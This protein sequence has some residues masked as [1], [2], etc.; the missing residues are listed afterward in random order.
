MVDKL[1]QKIGS[2]AEIVGKAIVDEGLVVKENGNVV[3]DSDHDIADSGLKAVKIDKPTLVTDTLLVGN[4]DEDMEHGMQFAVTPE[5]TLV[6]G[7]IRQPATDRNPTATFQNTTVANLTVN[8]LSEGLIVSNNFGELSVDS[9]VDLTELHALEGIS[10]NIQEQINDEVSN[11][12]SADNEL[13][14]KLDTEK[15][16]RE[17]EDDSLSGRI[18][19]EVS[20]RTSEVASLTEAIQTE[21]DARLEED[22][23]LNAK[24]DAEISDREEDVSELNNAVAGLT[25]NLN[26]ETTARTRKDSELQTA[27][28]TEVSTRTSEVSGLRTD[29]TTETTERTQ[30]ISGL[31]DSLNSEIAD[32]Q[33]ADGLLRTA[34]DNEV[35][36]RTN[37]DSALD[38][39]L[40][41]IEERIVLP[42]EGQ[43]TL[44]KTSDLN[45][46]IGQ[47]NIDLAK[48]V[49]K[50]TDTHS[51]T[52]V[53]YV[54][55]SGGD[56]TY[57]PISASATPDAIA[58]RNPNGTV[59]VPD[60]NMGGEA[61]NKSYVDSEVQYT[62][63][64]LQE[65]VDNRD[66]PH[67][68]SKEQLG[69]Q[70]VEN[71]P[72]D[73]D[74]MP[75]SPNYVSS[76][77]VSAVIDSVL[78]TIHAHTEDLDNPHRVSK[79]QLDL[80]NVVNRSMD[81]QPES[82]SMNYVESGGV[83]TA[84]QD[85]VGS[86]NAHE[87]DE[88]NPHNVTKEQVG[89]GNVDNTSDMNKP[90]STAQREEFNAI[91]SDLDEHIADKNNPH[92]VTKTQVGLQYVENY[93]MDAV[94]TSSSSN[95]VS[96]GGVYDEIER[97]VGLIDGH[98]SDDRNPHNVTKEQVGL[99]NVDNTS[100]MAKPVSTAQQTAIDGVQSNLDDHEDDTN[101]P[102]N[103]TKTQVGLGNVDNTSDMAK[104]VSTAQSVAIGN[105]QSALDTHEQT[106]ATASTYGHVKMDGT[107]GDGNRTDVT[108]SEAG[109]KAYVNS[110][111]GT[112]TA[113]FLGT[114]NAVADLGFTQTVVDTW[115]DPPASAVEST[116]GNAITSVLNA[117][118]ITPTS[119]DYVFVSVNE[120][121]TTDIDWYWRFK[122]DGSVWLYEYTL[123][124]SSFTQ[125][126]WDA[127]NS[128]IS[129][130][131]VSNYNNH[132]ASR[133]NPHG[134]TKAQVGLG[135]VDNTSDLSKPIS[136]ATQTALDN[137]VGTVN[138]TGS[139]Y[140]SAV[141]IDTND[142]TKLN[143]TRTAIPNVAVTG[144]TAESGKY[145]S[146]I[147]TNGHGI[148]VTK[149][150]LPSLSKGTTTGSGNVVS[151]IS[152]SE[153]TITLTKGITAIT[154][155]SGKA[156][157]NLNNISGLDTDNA[158]KAILVSSTG[159]IEFGEAG[160]VDDVQLNGTSV[161]SNK[162]ANLPAYP[163]VNNGTFNIQGNGTT[164]SSFGANQS[165]TTTL[166]IK[167][168]G[169]TTVT[170][171]ANNEITIS[172]GTI[173]TVNNGTLN[174]KGA[175]T[176]V[177]SFTAN[178]SATSNLD[179]V[180]DGSTT[181]TPDAT[182][183]KITISTPVLSTVATSGS[184]NDLSNKPTI[185]TVYNKT[186]KING[187]STTVA[188]FTS[189]SNTDV[190]VSVVG[191]GSTTVTPDATN[192]KITISTP[193]LSTVATSGS[194]NDLSN[195][196]TIPTVNNG[197]LNIQGNGTTAGSFTAN[198]SGT[199]NI[200]LV[201]GGGTTVT[202]DATNKKITISTTLPTVNNG[203]LTI[204]QNGTS[205]GTFSANQSS[206]G[207]I[208]LTDTWT[209]MT[210]ATSSADGTVGY[211]NA[212]PPKNGYNTKY[213]RADGTWTVPPDH[214]Y[215]VNNGTL[216]IKGENT[217]ATTFTA[218]SST[219]PTLAIKGSGA[220]TVTGASGT[221]TVSST[222]QSVTAVGNHYVPSG[223][224]TTSASG[225]ADTNITNLASGSGVN[226][227]TG[228]TLDDAGHVT[229]ITSKALRSVNNT[230]TVN[231]GKLSLQ[232]NGTEVASFTANQ[233]SGSTFNLANG[234]GISLT[235]DTTNKKI[236]VNGVAVSKTSA[237]L[238]PALPDETTTTKFLRQDGSWQVPAYPTVN[239]GT[240]SIQGNGTTASTFTANQSGNTTLNI[241]GS[242]GTSV[243][244]SANNEIT[245]SSTAVGNGTLT[246]KQN[247]TSK[248]TF[249]ANATGNTTVEL[250]DTTYSAGDGLTLSGTEIS[251]TYPI[252]YARPNETTST[253][254]L[255][256]TISNFPSAY[257]D[258]IM[259]ALRMPFNNVASSTLNVNGLG[260]KNVYYGN[261]T[262]TATRWGPAGCISLLVYETTTTTNGCWKAVYSW[263]SGNTDTKARQTLQTGNYNLPLL[264]SYVQTS[265][266]T[267]NRD[268]VTYRNNSIYANPSTGV[269]TA[270]GFA[271][272]LTGNVTGN[273][274]GSAGSVAWGNV[275]GRP[276]KLSDL[277]NDVVNN[278]TLTIQKNGTDVQTFTANQSTNATAN[279]TV[280]TKT[281]D[282]T[283]DSGFVTS[284]G[285]TSVATGVG[286]TGGTITG[287]GTIKA[288]LKSETASTL[289][290]A[291]ITSTASRQ[292]AVQVDK[293]GYLSVN[294]PWTNVNSGYVPT[295]RTV[296]SKALT[297]NI[298][299]SA[300]DV[301]ALANTT[302]YAG[303]GSVGGGATKLN[304]NDVSSTSPQYLLM[305]TGTGDQS[306]YRAKFATVT[307]TQP[308]QNQ[309][310][311]TVSNMTVTRANYAD[312]ADYAEDAD[313]ATSASTAT[314]ATKM[315]YR[316]TI[317]NRTFSRVSTTSTDVS[318]YAY[319]YRIS[320][321][322][323]S[324]DHVPVVT[325]GI[326]D[327][328]KNVWAP[329]CNVKTNGYLT[330]YSKSD[331]GSSVTVNCGYV[332]N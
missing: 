99:G 26:E 74:P 178:Q 200:N 198:A 15:T 244:K 17:S 216:T 328:N 157:T 177:T 269:I 126:Q 214:T 284:S 138:Q 332:L 267:A 150:A 134:V 96:S 221:I 196:P 262:T 38:S 56:E 291:T 327:L 63:D 236:T 229:G 131:K 8:D 108:I 22:N 173:P 201:G 152:V 321:S 120:S 166:N 159:G 47:V 240:L 330:I 259:I 89:L 179:I 313:N 75:D 116:V 276:T 304:V 133:S 183:K 206:N 235:N 19:D 43:D 207:T 118:S 73:T 161:V 141:A 107:I 110:S 145:I 163:T 25:A 18:D 318:G 278:A 252:Y 71:Y 264:M 13:Q 160:K 180:G 215:T 113:D 287:T 320:L 27:I 122:F 7:D 36:D 193:V 227:V 52:S 37:G 258:G 233:S 81:S 66:N 222:D 4:L 170:K 24:I 169:G 101:N 153:H 109:I 285:V 69:L 129:S 204:T 246:I 181:V 14:G 23:K 88:S 105:V 274:S 211:V 245:V 195:K 172:T 277:T 20:T 57:I 280:P 325:F 60:P 241:K 319:E 175:G 32:R 167:G 83:Y 35:R 90:V 275:S 282:L 1:T 243:T 301:G 270:P 322:G 9:T 261:N 187:E 271:G 40:D 286:L 251:E 65:H 95:Y 156:N 232:G 288:K 77:G 48:K 203:T 53:A 93:P 29:L 266:T 283:N 143:V 2:D 121:I 84:I 51:N 295:S 50:I 106:Y 148:S 290:S 197:T 42:W 137:K 46:A 82:G 130:T 124:N 92:E 302:K 79:E 296:N 292:Y 218:N 100:D 91:Q 140:V 62:R 33:N 208:A 307:V 257:K 61:T 219:S 248:G 176:T 72:M 289:D 194:Y 119:N 314:T 16:E 217:T 55:S 303:S 315:Q 312:S 30:A 21:S 310:W 80:G 39:R 76:G 308:S 309:L 273:V 139:G 192:K 213:L 155:V 10:N 329:I 190:T 135:N 67:G 185:P 168:S 297:G 162:I 249:T 184:Y 231:N 103:V 247:S 149:T 281:S 191:D 311:Y 226:V 127:I 151:D 234:T 250:T 253:A 154:D 294:V 34:I 5:E 263:D 306:I 305:S 199:T 147:A 298:T 272:N 49:D 209:P 158:G 132:V 210:G 242:G 111:I 114:Y 239:N 68:V 202:A 142:K 58:L 117:E 331:L 265:D 98:V 205:K 85:V 237:G 59:E 86:L 293:S 223:G 230:Y 125:A 136:T 300:S 279:I 104:P 144:G 123:N 188:S 44:A 45:N 102:H 212:I 189:N 115:T 12:T 182:N 164:A 31:T 87:N 299:L 97:V 171:S 317:G 3:I 224:T 41:A 268:G 94:P 255:T 64:A 174:L 220:T 146:A 128:G 28:E 228:V 6:G 316:A 186:L 256:A 324:T 238:C 54:Q 254:T 165:G 323:A 112:S 260:A 70:Y 326:P 11:R 78:G 225:G